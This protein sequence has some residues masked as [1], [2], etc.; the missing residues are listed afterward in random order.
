MADAAIIGEWS[1]RVEAEYRSAAHANCLTGWLI[2]IGASP[3]LIRDGLRIAGDELTHAEL[4]AEVVAKAGGALT[5]PVRRETLTLTRDEPVER[6]VFRATIEIFCLG[7]TLAVPL[8]RRMLAGAREP[9]AVAALRRIL[10]DEVRHRAFG[11]DVLEAL[12]EGPAR[13]VGASVIALDFSGML[14]RVRD[15]YGMGTIR[16]IPTEWRAWGLIAPGEY[17]DE[18]RRLEKTFAKVRRYSDNE[19]QSSPPEATS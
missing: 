3:D 5:E 1:R 13:A 19:A 9:V 18:F 14:R 4:S 10:A 6:A 2:E 12:M 11:W 15:A 17:A 7:E 16:E 8:F